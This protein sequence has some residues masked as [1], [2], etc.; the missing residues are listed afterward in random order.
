MALKELIQQL[1]TEGSTPCVTISLNTHR[2]RPDNEKDKI[3]LKN[4]LREAEERIVQEFGGKAVP[5]L[6]KKNSNGTKR[7]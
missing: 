5:E 2:T 4:L 6:L 1:G 7:N 3:L